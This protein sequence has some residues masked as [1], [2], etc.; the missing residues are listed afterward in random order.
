MTR[1]LRPAVGVRFKWSDTV[2][3]YFCDGIPVKVGDTA[4]VL[5]KGDR[6]TE[7]TVVELKEFSLRA[8]KGIIR[9]LPPDVRTDEQKAAKHPNGKPMWGRTGMLLDDKGN[10]SVFDDVDE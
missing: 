4:I 8:E 1:T 6:E 9:V 7:V 2:Y 5:T 3:D 10:R